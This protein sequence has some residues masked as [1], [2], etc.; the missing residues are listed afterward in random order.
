VAEVE[1]RPDTT[2][3]VIPSVPLA[4]VTPTAAVPDTAGVCVLVAVMAAL[5]EAGAVAGAV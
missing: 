5:P 1:V 2:T 3:E 4:A